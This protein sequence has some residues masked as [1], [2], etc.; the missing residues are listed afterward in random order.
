MTWLTCDRV[1]PK[2]TQDMDDDD[3]GSTDGKE[4]PLLQPLG[5]LSSSQDQNVLDLPEQ[6]Q[7]S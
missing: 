1:I 4:R 7:V 5:S 6:Q 2:Q 3:G